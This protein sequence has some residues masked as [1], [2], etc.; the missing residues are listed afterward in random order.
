VVPVDHVVNG[1]VDGVEVADVAAGPSRRPIVGRR[2]EEG[3]LTMFYQFDIM[4]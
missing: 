4:T 2:G 1:G 3:H